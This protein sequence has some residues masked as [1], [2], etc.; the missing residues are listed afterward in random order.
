MKQFSIPHELRSGATEAE[1]DCQAFFNL[2]VK[3]RMLCG[4]GVLGGSNAQQVK[5]IDRV[6]FEIQ[7]SPRNPWIYPEM[8]GLVDLLFEASAISNATL[9]KNFPKSKSYYRDG[10]FYPWGFLVKQTISLGVECLMLGHIFAVC[11]SGGLVSIIPIECLESHHSSDA[12]LLR[13]LHGQNDIRFMS[14]DKLL[15][16]DDL[17]STLGANV[18]SAAGNPVVPPSQAEHSSPSLE[19]PKQLEKRRLE[20][21]VV[22]LL[23]EFYSINPNKR[24]SSKDARG[25]IASMYCVGKKQFERIWK[26]FNV[27]RK[28]PSGVIPKEKTLTSDELEDFCRKNSVKY[29]LEINSPKK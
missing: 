10:E 4:I 22:S 19:M 25:V 9:E 24:V 1:L 12:A 13:Y 21:E 3:N 11:E 16:R 28:L 27:D 14:Y 2:H 7:V 5:N 8:Q 20:R 17:R 15:S 26:E 29:G 6:V 18:G 23:R